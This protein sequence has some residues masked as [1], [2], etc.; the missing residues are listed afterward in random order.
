MAPHRALVD[1][2]LLEPS[3][4]SSQSDAGEHTPLAA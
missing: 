1:S 2:F 3:E 4:E